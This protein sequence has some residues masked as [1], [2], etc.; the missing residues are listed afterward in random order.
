MGIPDDRAH[1]LSNSQE[2][3]ES[4]PL[5]M[6]DLHCFILME[7]DKLCKSA[8]C[9]MV[10]VDRGRN[11]NNKTFKLNASP[12]C[13]WLTPMSVRGECSLN[14]SVYVSVWGW[15]CVGVCGGVGVWVGVGVFETLI[16][17]L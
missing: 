4:S 8:V 13:P 14:V 5:H 15:G 10:M 12:S 11:D 1:K 16:T 17:L 7:D 2:E 3:F 6:L 9:V